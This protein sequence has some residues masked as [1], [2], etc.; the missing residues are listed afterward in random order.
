MELSAPLCSR[1]TYSVYVRMEKKYLTAAPLAVLILAFSGLPT[2]SQSDH[3]LAFIHIGV[4][5]VKTG[6]LKPD[7]TVLTSGGRITEIG[8]TATLRVPEDAG[9]FEGSGKYMLPALWNMHVHSVDYGAAIKAFPQLLASGVVG[10]RDMAAPLDT[11]LRLRNETDDQLVHRPHMLVS[12]P[13]LVGP[14]PPRLAA[15]K[16]IQA[17]NN[18]EDGKARV[19]SLKQAGVDFIKVNDSLPENIY[20]AIAAEAKR[21]HISFVGH[22]PP[23]I[24]AT[25]ASDMGQ[26]SIEHLGGP[27]NAVLIACSPREAGL[28]SRASAILK[29]EIEALFQ[30]AEDPDPGELRVAFTREILESYSERK[31]AAL[32][33][34]FRKNET[35]QVPTLVAMRGLWDRK[36]LSA[37]DRKYGEEIQ[38][39]Q[40]QVVGAMWRAGV[41]IMAGTDGPLSEAGPAL[42]RELALLVQAGLT[43]LAAIQAATLRPAEF[44]RKLDQFGS[45]ELGKTADFLILEANPLGDIANTKR[46]SAVVLGGKLVYST[47]H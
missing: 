46:I 37:E 40:L 12:G 10:V 1:C 9:L 3:R 7:M 4:L 21:E 35:W 41:K 13:M 28:K 24:G 23:S 8:R 44:M 25:K 18:P 14:I 42:H 22:V 38:Q 45:I 5:D 47:S 33:Q 27:H 29:A 19:R 31:A 43:P 20:A 11:V 15:M 17:V 26:R 34:R 39:K 32:F 2:H 30:G 6:E 36:D 16:L